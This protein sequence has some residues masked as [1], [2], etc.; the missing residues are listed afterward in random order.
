MCLFF[1]L[2][3]EILSW[4]EIK[5]CH[6]KYGTLFV[7]TLIWYIICATLAPPRPFEDLTIKQSRLQ[8]NF[9]LLI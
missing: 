2:K 1:I 8:L 3:N 6:E 7:S 5:A 9:E 4:D